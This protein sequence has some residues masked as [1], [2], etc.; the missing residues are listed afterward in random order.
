MSNV[1]CLETQNQKLQDD[2]KAAAQ[3]NQIQLD[4]FKS[5]EKFLKEKV[6]VPLAHVNYSVFPF[7]ALNLRSTGSNTT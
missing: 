2:L 4:L 7:Q 1:R 6:S 5:N 3:T